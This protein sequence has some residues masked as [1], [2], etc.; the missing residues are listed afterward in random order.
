METK[1]ELQWFEEV[2]QSWLKGVFVCWMLGDLLG[3]P[4]LRADVL[5]GG[6]HLLPELR[7]S[8]HRRDYAGT[9][10]L[11]AVIL[12]SVYKRDQL[13]SVGVSSCF[14]W[15]V[16]MYIWCKIK[17]ILITKQVINICAVASIWSVN[18]YSKTLQKLNY[19]ML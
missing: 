16:S 6:A 2:V 19:Q 4:D 14:S 15:L 7:G 1:E 5:S 10:L 9:P 3:R 12:I 17:K 13:F 18:T 8:R 11:S